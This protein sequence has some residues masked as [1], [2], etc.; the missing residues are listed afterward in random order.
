LEFKELIRKNFKLNPTPSQELLFDNLEKFLDS[1]AERSIFLLKG[2]AGT[3][4]T[5][6]LNSFIKT[7]PKFG[8]KSTLLAPTGRAA[9]VMANYSKKKAGTIHRKIYKQVEDSY[10]G[11]LVFEL[12]KNV[13]EGTIYVVDEA[14]MIGDQREFGQNGLLKDLI[15]YVFEGDQ[16]KLILIGDEAQLPPVGMSLSPALDIDHLANQYFAEVFS[17]ILVDVVR[18]GADSGILYNATLL[19]SNLDSKNL[20]ISLSTSAFKDIFKMGSDKL[21]DGIRYAYDKYGQENTVIITRSNKN[22]VQYNSFIRNR[23]NY[24]ENELEVGDLL[25]IVKNNYSILDEDSEAGFIANG[26][27]ARVLRI[28]REEEVHGFR[29]QHVSLKL[30][31]YPEDPEFDTLIFL[32]T[33][34]SHSP[35]LSAEQNKAL[36]ESVQKDYFWVKSKKEQKK[37][38]KADKYLNALQVK[39]AYALTCH[40]SQGG[41]WPVVFIDALYLPE[42]TLDKE[43]IRW[44]YTALTRGINEVYL[45]NFQSFLF[46]TAAKNE[47]EKK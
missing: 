25:M 36:Y 34:Y 39:F 11:Q 16:N 2:Y 20:D 13:A 21:E 33:L 37:L 41:Q 46:N 5:T 42:Q 35:S 17:S 4:K 14:S 22:A 3:G 9:K 10:N 29:F 38:I 26:E 45:I 12:Q 18:Q 19:R 8:W 47:T 6:F 44:L 7:I 15:Q 43:T 24:S 27:Y 32:E 23:I 40:K 31:D 28:G 1:E 30:I